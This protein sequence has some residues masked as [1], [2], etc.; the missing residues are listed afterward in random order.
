MRWVKAVNQTRGAVLAERAGMADS[1]FS[2]G[3][4]LIGKKDWEWGDGLVIQPCSSVHCFFMSIPL[5]IVYVDG[6]G[7]VCGQARNLKPWRL[8]PIVPRSRY[9][10]ELPAGTLATCGTEQGDLVALSELDQT[11]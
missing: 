2:R 7:R 4:G 1:F 5:D 11:A 6:H 3:R 10:L 8:G 9:V